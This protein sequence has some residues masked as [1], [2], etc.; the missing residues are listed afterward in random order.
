MTQW[1]IN[2]QKCCLPVNCFAF[3]C[4]VCI[5]TGNGEKRRCNGRRELEVGRAG[6]NA[7]NWAFV[8]GP[9]LGNLYL[10]SVTDERIKTIGI[11]RLR[12]FSISRE[13]RASRSHVTRTLPSGLRFEV[14]VCTAGPR[15]RGKWSTARFK[16][17]QSHV[18]E[19]RR[20]FI[21][22]LLIDNRIVFSKNRNFEDNFSA[23]I[24]LRAT[25][26]ES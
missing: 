19:E 10:A 8:Q 5:I 7:Q 2:N 1:R 25:T 12:F 3:S 9:R 23:K 14:H 17:S 16:T 13:P 18:W 6:N 22:L 20:L 15:S 4:L 11:L 26:R 24:E 21:T